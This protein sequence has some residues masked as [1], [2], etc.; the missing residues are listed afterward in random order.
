MRR[1]LDR[2]YEQAART[3]L[4]AIASSTSEGPIA[5]R[6]LELDV[7]AQRLLSVG[8]R[9]TPDNPVLRALLADLDPVLRQNTRRLA[10]ASEDLQAAG[11]RASATLVREIA[12]P[13]LNDQQ[14][15][16]FDI[17][18]NQPDPEAVNALVSYTTSAG[19]RDELSQYSPRV[20]EI[21]RNQAVRS[22]TEGW[23]PLRAANEI[24]RMTQDLPAAQAATFM[25]TVQLTSYRDASVIHQVANADILTSQIRIAALDDRTCMACV[26]LHGTRLPIGERI[27]DHHNGRCTSIA[28]VRGRPREVRSGEDWFSA[29]TEDQQREQL[30]DAAWLAWKEGKL[31]LRDLAVRYDDRVFG[32][33]IREG[34]L[35]GALGDAAAEYYRR[36]RDLRSQP[37]S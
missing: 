26:A 25:R 23:N 22:I 4:T 31:N 14:L 24:R 3:T 7:E 32:Q 37:R 28:E 17:R 34:S 21:I 12:L 13:G 9:L 33:M 1:L 16:A 6:L 36:A 2:G 15:A 18:W 20:Q 19:Y 11:I 30:G 8:Q 5:Q 10:L 35:S 27:D 29:R